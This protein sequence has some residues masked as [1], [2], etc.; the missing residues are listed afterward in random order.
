M[1]VRMY[2]HTSINM[3]QNYHWVTGRQGKVIYMLESMR[4]YYVNYT[5]I[6]YYYNTDF[7]TIGLRYV[8]VKYT[9]SKNLALELFTVPPHTSTTPCSARVQVVMISLVHAW[10]VYYILGD[11]A[12]QEYR[13]SLTVRQHNNNL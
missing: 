10:R 12:S 5:I 9:R 8:E 11:N 2:I 4:V 3:S 13:C 1:Y 7:T 6:S